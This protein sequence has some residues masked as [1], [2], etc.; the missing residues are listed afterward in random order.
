MTRHLKQWSL[1]DSATILSSSPAPDD[2]LLLTSLF[3]VK[4][5]MICLLV[6]AMRE[7]TS[8]CSLS[9][10]HFWSLGTIGRS[11]RLVSTDI[12]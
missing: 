1:A 3:N 5:E 10:G 7:A 12:N 8:T 11:T 6:A 9:A 2:K 4:V